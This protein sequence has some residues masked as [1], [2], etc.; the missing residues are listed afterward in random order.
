MY[1]VVVLSLYLCMALWLTEGVRFGRKVLK[2]KA[3]HGLATVA[4]EKPHGEALLKGD[5][6]KCLVHGLSFLEGALWSPESC[7]KCRCQNGVAS[8][9]SFPCT[10]AGPLSHPSPG[11]GDRALTQNPARTAV[12]SV[13][14]LAQ[15]ALAVA[16]RRV[17]RAG[18]EEEAGTRVEEMTSLVEGG[19]QGN[20]TMSEGRGLTESLPIGCVLSE[21]LIAC[22]KAGLT[23][24][25]VI[26]DPK[27]KVLS[28]S[29]NKIRHIPLNS[30][31]GLPN[32]EWLDLSKNKLSDSSLTQ[33]VFKNLGKL[34]RLNLDGNYLTKIPLLPPSLEE[35][36][37]ND[38]KIST[39]R[40]HSFKGLSRLLRLELE[41]NRL[42]EEG[43]SSLAFRPLRKLL[44]LKLD[45]NKF[46]TIPIGLPLSLQELHLSENKLEAVQEGV[47]NQTTKLKQL[48]LSHNRIRD[49]HIDPRALMQLQKLE[50]LDLSHNKL[51]RV[52][53]LL[54]PTLR[55]LFLHWNQ[56]DRIVGNIFGHLRPGLE[57]LRL[58]HNHLRDDGVTAFSFLGLYRSLVTLHLDH[59]Q[60][61]S[62]PPSLP[63]FKVLQL[64][65]LDH[66][67]IRYI[68]QNAFCNARVNKDSPLVS[69]HLEDNLIDHHL[70]PATAL[71]CVQSPAGI[72]LEPQS[73]K[74]QE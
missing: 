40:P 53:P 46:R 60:L 43:I 12:N 24:L 36:S 14:E 28:L 54:P 72:L 30:L 7:S 3:S 8:C 18:R 32:L 17:T 29:K 65:R 67:L 2:T 39:L 13:N 34:K 37:I 23:Y 74:Q 48:D 44:F 49:D 68:P 66:N 21:S 51:V 63:R 69:L 42:Q 31:A 15:T 52:P 64:L 35:L 6:S 22:R 57:V 25:P 20:V 71:S 55:Q 41:D 26:T 16:G 1:K 27:I 10:K 50:V 11:H 45:D 70:I 38:N 56:I 58:S 59:N 47:L 4:V 62:I 5:G 19:G 33:D 61:R 73:S 9:H